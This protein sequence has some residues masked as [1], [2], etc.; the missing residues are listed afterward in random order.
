MTATMRK[1][2]PTIIHSYS[3]NMIISTSQDKS[4]VVCS[5]TRDES[6]GCTK[7]RLTGHGHFVQDVAISSNGQFALSGSWDGEPCLW[8]LN[9]GATTYRFTGHSKDVLSVALSATNLQIVFALRDRS[10]KLWNTLNECKYTIQDGDAHTGWV[11][12]VKFSPVT[13]NPIIVSGSWDKSVKVWNLI[14]L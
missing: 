9:S 6:Y 1:A 5:L 10:I 7:K 13:A 4:L 14:N 12:C 11:S 2:E 3:T 8:Y